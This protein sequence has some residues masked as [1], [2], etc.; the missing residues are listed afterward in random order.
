[1]ASV[2]VFS[3]HTRDRH[4]VNVPSSSTCSG[5][6]SK[7]HGH[8]FS[9]RLLGTSRLWSAFISHSQRVIMH[10][11]KAVGI[12]RSLAGRSSCSSVCL[13]FLPPEV[14]GLTFTV[15]QNHLGSWWKTW[16]PQSQPQVFWF[17]SFLERTTLF[18]TNPSSQKGLLLTNFF[19]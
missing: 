4:L 15:H 7:V 14:V 16:I 3:L 9:L 1:M 11:F 8:T 18:L 12:S 17:N 10:F 6:A 5:F 2:W 13:P 19:T